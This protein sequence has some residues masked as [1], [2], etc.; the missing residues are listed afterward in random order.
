MSQEQKPAVAE[1]LSPGR[2]KLLRLEINSRVAQGAYSALSEW[3]LELLSEFKRLTAA[4]EEEESQ[5]GF[6]TPPL[7]LP[8]GAVRSGFPQSQ[9]DQHVEFANRRKAAISAQIARAKQQLDMVTEAMERHSEGNKGQ[10][11]VAAQLREHLDRT[12]L[13]PVEYL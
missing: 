4:H 2:A 8:R 6:S 7:S 11:A 13:K 3:R 1:G 5:G 10:T 9:I 12:E